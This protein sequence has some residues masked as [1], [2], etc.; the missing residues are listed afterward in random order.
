MN[1]AEEMAIKG[2][3]AV[4]TMVMSHPL[5]KPTMN[6]ANKLDRVIIVVGTFSPIASLIARHSADTFVEISLGLFMSK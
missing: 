2:R 6:P 5:T 1:M 4:E 3:P